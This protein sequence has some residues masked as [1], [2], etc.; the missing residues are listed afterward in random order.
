MNMPDSLKCLDVDQKL[1]IFKG[2]ESMAP[3]TFVG[4]KIM[5]LF[6]ANDDVR[7][8]RSGAG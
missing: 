8:G 1:V 4:E 6:E 3:C 2:H 7:H 5:P